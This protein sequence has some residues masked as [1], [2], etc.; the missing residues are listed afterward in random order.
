MN[1]PLPLGRGFQLHRDV[2]IMQKYRVVGKVYA[3]KYLGEFEANSPEEAVDLALN[4]DAASV[5]L[6]HQCSDQMAM[7]TI[8]IVDS[9]EDGV[10]IGAADTADQATDVATAFYA[11]VQGLCVAGVVRK[12]VTITETRLA[13]VIQ[14]RV[15]HP[16]VN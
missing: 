6:C 8:P 16:P 9:A 10:I 11:S 7:T 15:G 1:T 4:S 2:R 5:C 13:W 3:S 14:T 12:L